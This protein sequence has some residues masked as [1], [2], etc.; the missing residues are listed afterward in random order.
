VQ[1][2]ARPVTAPAAKT[3]LPAPR[4]APPASRRCCGLAARHSRFRCV[5]RPAGRRVGRPVRRHHRASRT[6]R[7]QGHRQP[8]QLIA[9]SVRWRERDKPRKHRA[10]CRVTSSKP[11]KPAGVPPAWLHLTVT[12]WRVYDTR[13]PPIWRSRQARRCRP[14]WAPIWVICTRC[15]GDGHRERPREHW[16]K[17]AIAGCNTVTGDNGSSTSP[18]QSGPRV[19]GDRSGDRSRAGSVPARHARQAVQDRGAR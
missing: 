16:R 10:I 1:Q 2:T 6:G 11:P 9:R 18:G 14:W 17:R 5:L 15:N 7:G 13:Y 3:T 12:A 8:R 4:P 19:R